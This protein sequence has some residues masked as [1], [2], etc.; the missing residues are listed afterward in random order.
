MQQK[1]ILKT[2]LNKSLCSLKL[3][4]YKGLKAMNTKKQTFLLFSSGSKK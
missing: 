3:N 1:N 4:T 2:N